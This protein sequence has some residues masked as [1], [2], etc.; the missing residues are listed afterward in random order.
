[1]QFMCEHVHVHVQQHA[2][3]LNQLLQFTQSSVVMS[4]RDCTCVRSLGVTLQR[5]SDIRTQRALNWWTNVL[6]ARENKGRLSDT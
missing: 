4:Q 5:L 6:A 1:M 3:A 2:A